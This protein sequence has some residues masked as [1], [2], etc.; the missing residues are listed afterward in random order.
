MDRQIYDRMRLIEDGHWW[1]KARRQILAGL[2][3]ALPAPAPARILE[4]GCGTGGNLS[5]LSSFG[6]VV[7]LEP[8][9]D[10][11]AYAAEKAGVP[12][13]GGLLPADLPFEPASFDLVCAFDVIEHVDDDAGAVRALA[14]L[15]KPGGFLATT[16]PAHPWMWSRHDEMHH[17]KRRYRLGPYRALFEAAGLAVV[18]ASY[19]NAA[20]FAPIAAA[21]AVKRLLGSTAADDEAIPPAPVNRLLTGVFGAEL[22]WLRRA[23]LPFGVSILLIA[24]RPA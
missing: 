14:A 7:G 3:G 23:S 1:F 17:H 19:F 20:L 8:D 24:R 6:E 5:M 12:V 16:V 18:K 4:V 13:Q 9:A 11:R 10:S 2:I 22:G 15:L 21:R